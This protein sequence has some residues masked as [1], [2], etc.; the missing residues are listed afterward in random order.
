MARAEN[1]DGTP[2]QL[3]L[4]ITRIVSEFTDLFK[5]GFAGWF[6]PARENDENDEIEESS[7]E[8]QNEQRSNRKSVEP[9]GKK[10]KKKE[11][12]KA[13]IKL[14]LIGALLKAKLTLLLKLLSA[15]LQVKFFLV[16]LAGLILNAARFYLDLKKGHHPQ[17]VIYYEHAQH[18]HHY[19]GGDEDWSSGPDNGGHGGGY[20]GRSYDDEAK[21]PHDLAYAKSKPVAAYK[22]DAATPS[23][24]SWF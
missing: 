7:E 1:Q 17:K 19:E 23:S 10:K 5:E 2:S 15:A 12:I 22:V 24:N 3:A 6:S 14:F 18:Q 20:W 8:D 16:A 4:T 21:S 9:R 13:L 11:K